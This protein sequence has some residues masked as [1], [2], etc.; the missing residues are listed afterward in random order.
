M[1]APAGRTLPQWLS[2]A[3]QIAAPITLISTLLFY[4]GYVYTK[5][6]YAYFGV[7]V[8]TIGL[9]P[10]D[11]VMRSPQPLLVPLL[12][13]VVLSV[14]AVALHGRL[15]AE[16][17]ERRL[18]PEGDAHIRRV[19]RRWV[20]GSSAVLGLGLVLL[21]AYAWWGAW[22]YLSLVSA[23]LIGVGAG[24]CAS[25]LPFATTKAPGVV[26]GLWVLVVAAAFWA[27]SITAEWSGRGQAQSVARNL[28]QLPAVILD[29]PADLHLRN[30]VAAPEDLCWL[31]GNAPDPDCA[32]LTD[33]P[34]YR[35][36]GLR[37]LVQGPSAM[38]LVP[39]QWSPSATTLMVPRDSDA[40][41]QFQFVNDSPF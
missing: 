41:L 39:T 17:D 37:L 36:R 1:A 30:T 20:I 19:A 26:A 25:A 7:D 2:T 16:A 38:F 31:S 22:L 5:S 34:R 6:Q 12:V 32:A 13:L 27:V 35:Y 21:L 10:R 40:R 23:C 15:R 29:S 33:E 11:Y 4:F 8:D 28:D 18:L 3:T 14:A 9:T 24:V